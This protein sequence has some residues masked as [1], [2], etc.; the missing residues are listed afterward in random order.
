MLVTIGLPRLKPT[1]SIGSNQPARNHDI[2]DQAEA[3][4]THDQ[5]GEPASDSANE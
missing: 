2:A 1:P 4:P 5:A 3:K